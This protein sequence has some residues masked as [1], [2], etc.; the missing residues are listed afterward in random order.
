MPLDYSI[1]T[2]VEWDREILK[3][4]KQKGEH[5]DLQRRDSK[6]YVYVA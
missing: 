4:I 6:E 3:D 5:V 1:F 2:G